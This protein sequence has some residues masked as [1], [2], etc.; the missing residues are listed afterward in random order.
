MSPQPVAAECAFA[1]ADGVPEAETG[2][3]SVARFADAD[4]A[5]TVA[6]PS[7]AVRSYLKLFQCVAVYVSDGDR[8]SVSLD[9]FAPKHPRIA[10]VW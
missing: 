6:I 2:D 4:P 7:T 5:P 1:S 8:V 9:P 3:R 10:G